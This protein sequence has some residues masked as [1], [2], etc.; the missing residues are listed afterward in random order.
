MEQD[1]GDDT[2][3]EQFL[4]NGCEETQKHRSQNQGQRPT[5]ATLGV[6]TLNIFGVASDLNP[7]QNRQSL[8]HDGNQSD[9]DRDEQP[10]PRS[11]ADTEGA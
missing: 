4:A 5:T 1:G 11:G 9:S 6:H 2:S 8:E 7:A 10:A 3:E